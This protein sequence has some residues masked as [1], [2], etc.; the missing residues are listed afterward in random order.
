MIIC[1]C[2]TISESDVVNAA[3]NGCGTF[4]E[5]IIKLGRES[6]NKDCNI[7]HAEMRKLFEGLK[8]DI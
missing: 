6:P 5:M 1:I 8:E 2:K 4:E 7:C 3:L